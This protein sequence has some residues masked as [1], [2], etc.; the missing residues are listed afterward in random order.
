MAKQS[1]KSRPSWFTARFDQTSEWATLHVPEEWAAEWLLGAARLFNETTL[2]WEL[3]GIQSI[4]LDQ[5]KRRKWAKVSPWHLVHHLKVAHDVKIGMTQ[6]LP[7]PYR[8]WPM[9]I[10]QALYLA[11]CIM[12]GHAMIEDNPAE[13]F[14]LAALASIPLAVRPALAA[15][16]PLW[17]CLAEPAVREAVHYHRSHHEAGFDAGLLQLMTELE[18]APEPARSFTLINET[19]EL[20]L[21]RIEAMPELRKADHHYV[22]RRAEGNIPSEVFFALHDLLKRDSAA[23][24]L[25]RAMQ[26]ELDEWP[27]MVRQNVQGAKP[28]LIITFDDTP[29][30]LIN[31][32]YPDAA[33]LQEQVNREQAFHAADRLMEILRDDVTLPSDLRKL[34][35]MLAADAEQSNVALASALGVTSATIGTWKKKL[36]ARYP[37]L[38]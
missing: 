26:G 9:E 24:A 27:E 17:H 21:K 6:F 34:L 25:A 22:S 13:D 38:R 10:R 35:E 11:H 4:L 30:W 33:A 19:P 32:G 8:G 12:K 3:V 5:I 1:S 20:L 7:P 2:W 15:V 18:D 29:T 37:D 16:Q 23:S 36:A 14:G 28:E 31:G